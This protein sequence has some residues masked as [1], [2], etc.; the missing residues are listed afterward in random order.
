MARRLGWLCLFSLIFFMH[1]NSLSCIVALCSWNKINF[2]YKEKNVNS[3]WQL[4]KDVS[5]MIYFIYII[6]N[7]EDC[8]WYLLL[9]TRKNLSQSEQALFLSG[10]ILIFSFVK[11]PLKTAKSLYPIYP[12]INKLWALLK[13]V[14]RLGHERGKF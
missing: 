6:H 9:G 8:K 7:L 10:S 11:F 13:R 12:Y 5:F 1:I 14:G 2:Y 3:C 4:F